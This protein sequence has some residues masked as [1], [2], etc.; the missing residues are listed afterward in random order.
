MCVIYKN[1]RKDKIEQA[2]IGE[3]LILGLCRKKR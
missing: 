2:S 1:N 3:A